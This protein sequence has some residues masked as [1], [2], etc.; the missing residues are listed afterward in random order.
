MTSNVGKL[1]ITVYILFS[2]FASWAQARADW[3]EDK[4]QSWVES[5]FQ[6]MTLEEKIAQLFI[7]R[8]HSDKGQAHEKKVAA[9]IKN[10]QVGGVCFFQGGPARQAILTNRYQSLADIPLFVAQDAE[11]G[12]GMRLDSTVSFPRQMTLGAMNNK[13]LVYDIARE[14]AAHCKRIG[15]NMNFAP[16]ADINNNPENPVIN[17]RSFGQNRIDVADNAS[18]YMYGLQDNGIIATA[19]HFPGHGDTDTDS[20][21]RL[22]I[23]NKNKKRL[24]SLELY[25]FKQLIEKGVSAIMAAHLNVPA[26]DSSNKA[27][28]LSKKVINNLLREEMNFEG[29]IITDAL[30]MKGL[31]DHDKPGKVAVEALKAGN[32]ILLLPVDL[33]KSLKAVKEAV[34]DSVIS[35]QIINQKVKRILDFKQR[36][37]IHRTKKANVDNIQQTL[38]GPVVSQLMRR[39]AENAVTLVKNSDSILPFRRPDTMKMASV[40]IGVKKKQTFQ[41]ALDFYQKMPHF[42]IGKTPTGKQRKK[43]LKKLKSFDRV[44]LSVHNTS[45]YP[46]KNF[47]ITDAEADL[48]DTIAAQNSTVLDIFGIPYT[49]KRLINPERFESILISYEDRK[50]FQEVSGQVIFGGLPALGKLPVTADSLYPVGKGLHTQKIRLSFSDS[51]Q[52][53]IKKKFIR[54]IDSIIRDGM[55][56]KA[57]PGGQVLMAHKGN[58]FFNKSYGYHTYEK[59]RKTKN[60]DLYDIASITKI[61]ATTLAVMKL[62]EK[63]FMN[64]DRRIS[65]YIPYLRH[66][67]KKNIFI[68]ELMAHQA[69][70]Q[71][72]I[73]YYE[74]TIVDDSLDG[75]VYHN[76]L[77]EKYN[78][79]VAENLYIHKN[80]SHAIFDTIAASALRDTNDYEYSDLGF[81]LL[82]Q[83]IENVINEPFE[84]YV[85]EK[86]YKPLGL[87]TM[88][89]LPR[90]RFNLERIVPTEED[91]IFRHQLIH[92]DVHDPGAAMLGGVSGHAGVFSNARDLAV[93]MQMLLNGGHYGGKKYLDPTTVKQFTKTQFPLNNN[94]KAIGFDKPVTEDDKEGPSAKAASNK[95]FGHTGFT[96]TITWAD[97]ENQSVFVFLSNRVYPDASNR[98]LIT[99]DIRTKIHSVLYEAIEELNQ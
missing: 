54:R 64:V 37:D 88:G 47:G 74:K 31:T 46:F 92:G 43:L 27:T 97:P 59:K 45:S 70:L 34:K 6:D 23:I 21:I 16:V 95:S 99:K 33:Q 13:G 91:K 61:A 52:S 4:S 58:V 5:T 26:L 8:A 7:I 96:G 10:H 76:Q 84:K 19:K 15:V 83:A 66:S 28:T 14:I 49:I 80:Y 55:E 17:S 39:S 40:A 67:N 25:P 69:R 2:G 48:L 44:I 94:R 38:H 57:F 51:E 72:W 56:R 79:R 62:S 22:P 87:E 29:L 81:Y 50:V 89:F 60:T 32:D 86:F 36:Y 93:M 85:K 3:P 77:T 24:D 1:I 41:N 11:W 75:D 68:R 30:E 9:L 18:M 63:E 90:Y 42:Q 20:H 73:P 12:L 98:K 78:R 82:Y 35:E 65:H 71:S 53:G